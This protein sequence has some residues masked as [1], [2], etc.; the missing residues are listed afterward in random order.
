MKVKRILGAVMASFC[1]LFAVGQFSSVKAAIDGIDVIAQTK[2]NEWFQN[3]D[4]VGQGTW[5][6]TNEKVSVDA[7]GCNYAMEGATYLTSVAPYSTVAG[8][9]VVAFPFRIAIR[10][11]VTTIF[12]D[13]E[14]AKFH[15]KKEAIPN[16]KRMPTIAINTPALSPHDTH[17]NPNTNIGNPIPTN[18]LQNSTLGRFLYHFWYNN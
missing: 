12:C 15:L 13:M 7:F 1:T 5:T 4:S 3:E 6:A 14:I 9:V 17:K 11:S 2:E 8:E 18:I 16:T 10:A